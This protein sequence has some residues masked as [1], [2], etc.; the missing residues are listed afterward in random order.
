MFIYL[1]FVNIIKMKLDEMDLEILRILQDN[2]K[3][4]ASD[5][6]KK[7]G[8]IPTTVYAKIHRLEEE[9]IIKDY[10]AIL[11][12]KKLGFDVTAIILVS[13]NYNTIGDKKLSQRE[14]LKKLSRFA[15][16]SEAQMISGDWDMM[17]KIKA[18]NVDEVGK[19]VIDKLRTVDGIDKVV[20]SVVF[21]TGKEGGKIGL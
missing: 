15:E 17:L 13:F 21:D 5:I 6:A 3:S 20:T 4:S 10:T 1:F 11:D 19:F 2:C 7:I 16:V 18:K 14:A 9:G 12:G 8:S